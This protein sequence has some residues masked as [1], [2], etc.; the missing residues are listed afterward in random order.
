MVLQLPTLKKITVAFFCKYVCANITIYI[1][2]CVF[3]Y[4]Y[5]HIYMYIYIYMNVWKY[6]YMYVRMYVC[7]YVRMYVLCMYVRSKSN[8]VSYHLWAKMLHPKD[9]PHSFWKPKKRGGGIFQVVRRNISQK[10]LAL[11]LP[12][13]SRVKGGDVLDFYLCF[14]WNT[15]ASWSGFRS[16]LSMPPFILRKWCAG[17]GG[18]GKD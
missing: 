7:T 9:P 18:Q 8:G 11:P 2:T 3:K 15:S 4:M 12:K 6:E 10:F 17:R 13:Y 1:Y 5:V 16:F 14:W